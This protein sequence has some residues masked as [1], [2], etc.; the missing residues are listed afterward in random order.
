MKDQ[1]KTLEELIGKNKAFFES[2]KA[3][4]QL[5]KIKQELK[6]K[7][8][9]GNKDKHY[10]KSLAEKWS[11][12]RLSQLQ[13]AW[14]KDKKVLDIGCNQGIVDLLIAVR[15]QPKLIIGVDI[16]HRM[17]KNAIDNMQK[18]INDQGQMELLVDQ[19]RKQRGKE[20]QE[21]EDAQQAEKQKLVAAREQRLKELLQ[22]VEA[23]PVS[24]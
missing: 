14:L 1:E 23:L 22:R 19:I 20:D 13:S 10:K 5:A 11:D 15:H 6:V 16:D 8:S 9:F 24:L 12:S 7:Q 3:E 21:M 18:V 2:L 17:V 4:D